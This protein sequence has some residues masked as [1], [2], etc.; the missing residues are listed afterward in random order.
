MLCPVGCELFDLEERHLVNYGVAIPAGG[1]K[2]TVDFSPMITAPEIA[3]EGDPG[4]VLTTPE[5]IPG[6]AAS[7]TAVMP[8]FRPEPVRTA[9]S[10]AL[11]L[12][13]SI[14]FSTFPGVISG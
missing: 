13:R 2:Q 10:T 12:P 6:A 4:L 1:G 11:A 7:P 8:C 14:K 3:S 5:P 9:F